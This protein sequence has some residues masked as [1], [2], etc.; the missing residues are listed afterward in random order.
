MKAQMKGVAIAI[1]MLCVGLVLPVYA[2]NG[3]PAARMIVIDNR[4]GYP[5]YDA[6]SLPVGP[7]DVREVFFFHIWGRT[8]PGV[9]IRLGGA[10]RVQLP[11]GSVVNIP[12]E[13]ANLPR[14]TNP[15]GSLTFDYP[16][17]GTVTLPP[18][19]VYIPPGEDPPGAVENEGEVGFAEPLENPADFPGWS[20]Y[21]GALITLGWT[22]DDLVNVGLAIPGGFEGDYAWYDWSITNVNGT[23]TIRCQETPEL[24]TWV[25]LG[26]GIPLFARFRDRR[27]KES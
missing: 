3:Y 9:A 16:D 22:A 17:G 23:D 19:T 1:A 18:G 12:E 15:D 8:V 20:D 5:I 25:L 2:S 11:N 21:E 10:A 27:R 4:G 24:G 7:T 6:T 14:T 13:A 26:L